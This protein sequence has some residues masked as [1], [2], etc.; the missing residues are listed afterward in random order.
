MPHL[1]PAASAAFP[2]DQSLFTL[3]EDPV[4]Q[5]DAAKQSVQG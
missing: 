1:K 2:C 3:D 4:V 5:T